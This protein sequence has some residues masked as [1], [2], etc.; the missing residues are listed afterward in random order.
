MRL[1]SRAGGVT[2]HVCGKDVKSWINRKFFFFFLAAFTACPAICVSAPNKAEISNIE[3]DRSGKNLEA[4]FRL[5]DCF[6][7]DME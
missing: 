1:E 3:I 5:I 6:N 7:S 2:R 4:S